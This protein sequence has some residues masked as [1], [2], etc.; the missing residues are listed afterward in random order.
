MLFQFVADLFTSFLLHSFIP[1]ETLKGVI[2]PII[3]DK[4]MNVTMSDNY[5]PVMTSSV[6]L[7]LFE[8]CILIKLDPYIKVND[9]QHGFRKNYSTAT[10]C[11]VLKETVLNY[12]NSGS[13][14]Y[15]CFLDI[16]KAFD[17]VNHN[18]LFN[19]LYKMEIPDYLINVMRFW[20]G[21]QFVCVK[22]QDAFSDEWRL[23]NGVRQGGV[24]SGLLFS[25][26]IDNLIS[27]VSESALGCMLGI[28]KSNVI[29]YADD[30]VIFA[31]SRPA[32]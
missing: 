26:Y 23:M 31:P 11:F 8:Y 6:F 22:Y 13:N 7:K 14:V 16:S 28:S 4:F 9:R 15:S 1:L 19:K 29:A 3:K 10:A 17:S 2:T 27:K 30:I 24:L 32:L 18:I 12:T 20:Y 5:R 25:I 21:N